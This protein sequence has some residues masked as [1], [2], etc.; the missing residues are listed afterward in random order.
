MKKIIFLFCLAITAGV[1]AQTDTTSKFYKAMKKQ[2][3]IVDTAFSLPSLQQAYNGFE[4]IANAEKKEW[5]PSYYMA[6]CLV[7][8]SYLDDVNKADEYCDQASRQLDHADSISPNNS[9]IFVL[10]AMC[11]SARIRVNPMTRGAKY[12]KESGEW[13]GKAQAADSMNP[14]VP[15]LQAQGLYYMPPAFGGGKDKAKPVFEEAIRKYDAFKPSS[16][17]HPHWGR[18]R[19][20]QL[21]NECNK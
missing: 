9:E 21:L 11:A 17:I 7:M 3:A 6:Y 12:G 10:R 4:R 13:L 5:L 14:R 15:Y 18:H 1:S 20:Q 19:A 2:V 8:E 16:P